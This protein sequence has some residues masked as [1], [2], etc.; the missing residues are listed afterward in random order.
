MGLLALNLL[1]SVLP[2]PLELLRF[3]L[4]GSPWLPPFRPLLMEA[5]LLNSA[6]RG[7][8]TSFFRT[9]KTRW[10]SYPTFPWL[11]TLPPP[12]S[13]FPAN[14]LPFLKSLLPLGELAIPLLCLEPLI[15]SVRISLS[16]PIAPRLSFEGAPNSKEREFALLGPPPGQRTCRKLR[17]P[18]SAPYVAYLPSPSPYPNVGL[19][20]YWEG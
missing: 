7:L 6:T 11:L 15:P 13:L 3:L 19:P 16:F 18:L 4:I 1:E 20:M 8:A 14:L 17:F 9:W 2:P 10:T 12:Y 5:S